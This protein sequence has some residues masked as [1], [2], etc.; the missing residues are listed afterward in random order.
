MYA[1]R[2]E[3]KLQIRIFLFQSLSHFGCGNG[4]I[5]LHYLTKVTA[6]WIGG[7]S[8][9]GSGVTIDLSLSRLTKSYTVDFGK[10]VKRVISAGYLPKAGLHNKETQ[11]SKAG[12]QLF[13]VLQTL[14]RLTVFH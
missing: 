12:L 14:N 7:L 2:Y 1:E 6:L 5:V 10:P 8:G 13:F 9:M 3:R 11:N 4:I